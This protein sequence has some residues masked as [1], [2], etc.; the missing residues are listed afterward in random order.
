MFW[1]VKEEIYGILR[2]NIQW[3]FEHYQVYILNGQNIAKRLLYS[4]VFKKIMA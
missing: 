4:I 3:L 1:Q 2:T